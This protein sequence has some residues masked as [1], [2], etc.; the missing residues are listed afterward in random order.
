M[1]DY[2]Q[3]EILLKLN[4]KHALNN[5][6]GKILP[7]IVNTETDTSGHQPLMRD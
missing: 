1:V 3:L 2:A 5:S 6:K 4:V 7:M